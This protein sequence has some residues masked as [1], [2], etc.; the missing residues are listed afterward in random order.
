ML[1]RLSTVA[2]LIL[3]L[4]IDLPLPV[5]GFVVLRLPKALTLLRV[6][7]LFAVDPQIEV[8]R[9]NRFVSRMGA[10]LSHRK[11]SHVLLVDEDPRSSEE[12]SI[13]LMSQ[14][15]HV[16]WA[17]S[18]TAALEAL[19]TQDFEVALVEV[20]LSDVTGVELVRL[21][22]ERSPSLLP[23][24]IASRPSLESAVAAVRVGAFDYLLKPIDDVR[25]TQVVR[26]A[27]RAKAIID[28]H[29]GDLARQ[30]APAASA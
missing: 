5:R 27:I 22:I 3:L 20:A 14:G 2:S 28:A 13:M 11:S 12:I 26:E 17:S 4:A 15:L 16:T 29:A 9:P 30:V 19:E 8:V 1:T 6:L 10:T 7:G 21:L 18:S 25:L 23:I 24:L